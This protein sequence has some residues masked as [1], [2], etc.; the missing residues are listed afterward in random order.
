MEHLLHRNGFIHTNHDNTSENNGKHS[1]VIM[2]NVEIIRATN[3]GNEYIE[4]TYCSN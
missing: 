2:A 4:T 1:K 3:C